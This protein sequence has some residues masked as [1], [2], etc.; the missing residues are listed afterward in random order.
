MVEFVYLLPLIYVRFVPRADLVLKLHRRGK[1]GSNIWYCEVK[2][3]RKTRKVKGYILD[4]LSHT[5]W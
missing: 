1:E 4:N 5:V 2:G 3:S